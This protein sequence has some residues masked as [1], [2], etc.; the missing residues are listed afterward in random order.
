MQQP[1]G[2][3]ARPAA[4]ELDRSSRG[5]DGRVEGIAAAMG[6]SRAIH[7]ESLS[8]RSRSEGHAP[9]GRGERGL[10]ESSSSGAPPHGHRERAPDLTPKPLDRLVTLLGRTTP[11]QSCEDGM[12]SDR[13]RGQ[14][15]LAGLLAA[16]ARAVGAGLTERVVLLLDNAGWHSLHSLAVPD[17]LRLV[18]LPAPQALNRG[19]PRRSGR[20]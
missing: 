1:W 15:P 4:A 13:Q 18:Y 8:D 12:T 3:R 2:C 5:D 9:E 17:G 10:R 6:C 14:P 7:L 20:S 16:S 11:V 19:P